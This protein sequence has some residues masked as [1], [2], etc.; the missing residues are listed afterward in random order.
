MTDRGRGPTLPDATLPAS[1]GRIHQSDAFRVVEVTG[2]TIEALWS[3]S[4]RT[5]NVEMVFLK[6]RGLPWQRFCLCV[7][8]GI[9]EEWSDAETFEYYDGVPLTDYGLQYGVIGHRLHRAEC[10]PSESDRAAKIVLDIESCGR[11]ELRPIAPHDGDPDATFV[12]V[13]TPCAT[14]G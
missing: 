13:E 8:L 4:E 3:A 14:S 2:L 10:I 7:G 6:L 5:E 12:R 11:L 1:R 9:W